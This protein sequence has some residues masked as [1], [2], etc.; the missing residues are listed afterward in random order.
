[1]LPLFVLAERGCFGSNLNA[2][3]ARVGSYCR[4]PQRG[5]VTGACQTRS[6]RVP[7]FPIPQETTPCISPRC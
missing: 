5:P 2:G 6:D 4:H 3:G 1:M 7:F